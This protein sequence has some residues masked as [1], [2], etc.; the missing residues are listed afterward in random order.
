M[1]DSDFEFDDLLTTAIAIV[2]FPFALFC[3]FCSTRSGEAAAPERPASVPDDAPVDTSD[4]H[5]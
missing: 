3:A 5:P 2:I 1:S 4:S